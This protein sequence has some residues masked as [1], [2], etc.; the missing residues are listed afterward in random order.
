MIIAASFFVNILRRGTSIS[1]FDIV[2]GIFEALPDPKNKAARQVL[3]TLV[4]L[5]AVILLILAM[6]R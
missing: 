5:G 3:A 4:V 6:L 2:S 1:I